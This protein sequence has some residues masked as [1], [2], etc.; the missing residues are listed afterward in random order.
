MPQVLIANN[1]IAAVKCI[2]SIRRWAYEVLQDDKGIQFVA[3]A[4]PEDVQTNAGM[5]SILLLKSKLTQIPVA[6]ARGSVRILLQSVLRS[7]ALL[8]RNLMMART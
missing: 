4:T 8:E 2:R 1:G 6:K 3:M 7:T 5:Y